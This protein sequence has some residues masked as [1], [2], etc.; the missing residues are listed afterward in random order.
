MTKNELRQKIG[1]KDIYRN[2]D[3]IF[4]YLDNE[5]KLLVKDEKIYDISEYDSFHK[6]ITMNNID[7]VLVSK[8][9]SLSLVNL[10]TKDI[11]FEDDK[12]F[13]VK[14]EDERCIYV[15]MKIGCGDDSIY[16]IETKDYL[17]IPSEYEFEHSLENNLY[18]YSEKDK[19]FE[20]EFLDRKR[21]VLN[22]N[23]KVLLKDIT[24]W[25]NYCG[26]YLVINNDDKI[27]IINLNDEGN[28]EEKTV[29]FN[30]SLLTKPIF[31]DG[32]IVL[33]KEGLI[34][35]YDLELNLIKS[36]EASNL[37]KVIDYELTNNTLKFCVPYQD[38]NKHLF[39]NL[40]S[41]KTISHVRIEPHPW[42][43]PTT[44]IGREKIN[45]E[46]QDYYFYDEEFNLRKKI[47]GKKIYSVDSKKECMFY[48]ESD[49][50]K[51]FLNMETGLLKDVSYD[52]MYFHLSL[53]YGYGVNYD[54]EKMDFFD[55]GLNVIIK[56][57][58][59]KKYNIGIDHTQFGYFIIKDY[60][61]I[62]KHVVDGRGLSHFR[63][64][65]EKNG[66]QVILDA[67]DCK[68][69]PLGNYIQIIKDG[70]TKYFNTEVDEFTPLSIMVP[71]NEK[72]KIDITKQ[73]SLKESLSLI[74]KG[75]QK[76][77]KL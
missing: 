11:V 69:Y 21:V 26:N 55:E 76:A 65:I 27:R 61:C 56:D 5:Q 36:I 10:E 71:V 57:F 35:I 31:Y 3:Y 45:D 32:K 42:W 28:I 13:D 64:I 60:L 38:T 8:D 73:S 74:D 29:E 30:K 41:D 23:G 72:G 18:V 77:K 20:K 4:V 12:A 2:D 52:Y 7:Y 54:T 6:V 19:S 15:F 34:E 33:V 25:I 62:S 75:F 47:N 67:Y 50:R 40:K 63:E 59:Y 53:P 51:Q 39:V 16:N 24:G 48:I 43:I 22:A 46:E 37:N 17:N 66:G 70:E 49:N 9:Y 44:Y 14:K 1:I 58:D 68:V